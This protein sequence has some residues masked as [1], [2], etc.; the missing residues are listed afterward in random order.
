MMDPYA[1]PLCQ[2]A[3]ICHL[4]MWELFHVECWFWASATVR[5]CYLLPSS[6]SGFWSTSQIWRTHVMVVMAW[7]W[8]HL[9]I[10]CIWRLSTSFNM[11]SVDAG[12]ILCWVIASA[13]MIALF[14]AQLCHRFE[15]SFQFWANTCGVVLAWWWLHMPIHCIWRLST[16][17]HM[18]SVN[19]GA[20]LCWVI[21]S[22]TMIAL[23][24][25][26]LCHRFEL[27]FQFWANTCGVVLAWWWLHMPI[28]C[29]WRLSS[30]VYMS[31]VDVGIILPCW[32]RASAT[33]R[34]CCSWP[35]SVTGLSCLSKSGLTGMMMAPYAHPL[36]LKVVKQ[37]LYV[38][39]GCVN[40]SMLV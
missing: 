3:F 31:S 17:F 9:P 39:C 28:H 24:V 32:F 7:W 23:F 14:V 15:L 33:V 20:I 40:S 38:I 10:H 8:L 27:S 26:Q 37:F 30:S 18:S 6:E 35:S 13:T 19:V 11:S 5:R 21:A 25:A 1:H 2:T 34:Y 36:H 16:S 4:W 12:A 22:A 29:I